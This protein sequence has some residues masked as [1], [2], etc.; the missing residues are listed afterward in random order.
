MQVPN[1]I[2]I[3]VIAIYWILFRIPAIIREKLKKKAVEKEKL[4]LI[5]E[6]PLIL[7]IIFY[8]LAIYFVISKI[9][10]MAILNWNNLV[11]FWSFL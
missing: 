2:F 7:S 4:K 6:L 8:I 1:L 3:L 9:L 10:Y 11:Y 5:G